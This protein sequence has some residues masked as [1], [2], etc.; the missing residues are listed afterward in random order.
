[1]LK[2]T[3]M[4]VCILILLEKY[5]YAF[6]FWNYGNFLAELLNHVIEI[7]RNAVKTII[8]AVST[9]ISGVVNPPPP[10]PTKQVT[11]PSTQSRGLT[12]LKKRDIGTP[13]AGTRVKRPSSK[14]RRNSVQNSGRHVNKESKSGVRKNSNKVSTP[15]LDRDRHSFENLRKLSEIFRYEKGEE[16]QFRLI[17]LAYLNPPVKYS[18]YITSVPSWNFGVQGDLLIPLLAALSSL[19]LI[20]VSKRKKDPK[21][22]TQH[23]KSTVQKKESQGLSGKIQR[24]FDWVNNG[25]ESLRKSVSNALNSV[26]EGVTSYFKDF[27]DFYAGVFSKPKESLENAFSAIKGFG[28]A[29]AVGWNNFTRDPLGSLRWVGEK[30]WENKEEIIGGIIVGGAIVAT[31][32]TAGAAGISIPYA[33]GAAAAIGGGAMGIHYLSRRYGED[34]IRIDKGIKK[35]EFSCSPAFNQLIFITPPLAMASCRVKVDEEEVRRNRK[36]LEKVGENAIVDAS[37]TLGSIGVGKLYEN[38]VI[39]NVNRDV[40]FIRDV[41]SLRKVE[42]VSKEFKSSPVWKFFKRENFRLA[43]RD[44]KGK[45]VWSRILFPR[46][47]S[48]KIRRVVFQERGDDFVLAVGMKGFSDGIHVLEENSLLVNIDSWNFVKQNPRLIIHEFGDYLGTLKGLTKKVLIKLEKENLLN[49][50]AFEIVNNRLFGDYYLIKSEGCAGVETW[51]TVVRREV[52]SL[53]NLMIKYPEVRKDLLPDLAYY[54]LISKE[55]KQETFLNILRKSIESLSVEERKAFN[56]YLEIFEE[57][58]RNWG[59]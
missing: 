15:L 38:A 52:D 6:P 46:G 13:K 57:G 26:A 39:W 17:G 12:S 31:V 42:R 50:R 48:Q 30:I 56:R 8:E 21:K 29:V 59:Y 37:I 47:E 28:K 5:A 18:S 33:L 24:L 34:L 4:I 22:R 45:I 3:L 44:K 20:K 36:L 53:T 7:V 25:L 9:V 43:I 54:Y 58:V 10:S 49:R 1:M 2:R 14:P 16:N 40:E 51:S 11:Q 27:V 35:L 32:F 23:L 41:G 19:G 55:G